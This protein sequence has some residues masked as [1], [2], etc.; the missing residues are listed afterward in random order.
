VSCGSNHAGFAEALEPEVVIYP[1]GASEH[2][3]CAAVQHYLSFVSAYEDHRFGCLAQSPPRHAGLG[4]NDP[5]WDGDPVFYLDPT[6]AARNRHAGPDPE[7]AGSLDPRQV[8][9]DA[10][11]LL[12]PVGANAIKASDHF[13][14]TT[15]ETGHVRVTITMSKADEASAPVSDGYDLQVAKSGPWVSTT[16]TTMPPTPAPTAHDELRKRMADMIPV[17]PPDILSLTALPDGTML[18]T[19]QEGRAWHLAS[20]ID[21][22]HWTGPLE[23]DADGI[24]AVPLADGRIYQVTWDETAVDGGLS[25]FTELGTFYSNDDYLDDD[26]A[27]PWYGSPELCA[28]RCLMTEKCGRFTY[29]WPDSGARGNFCTLFEED[30]EPLP[31]TSGAYRMYELR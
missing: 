26:A 17:T 10:S 21:S 11:G 28:E 9:E 12:Q 20:S 19:D 14:L 31:S 13:V 3:R 2:P 23:P 29:G 8:Y 25:L 15:Q 1:A 5:W 18:G 24:V 7:Q 27:T 16:T 6:N 30:A 4:R 22:E